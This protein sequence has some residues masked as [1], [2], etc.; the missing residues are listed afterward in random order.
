ML[1]LNDY[2]VYTNNLEQKLSKQDAI[3][4]AIT[5]S[6]KQLE[7]MLS[8]V[9]SEKR[10]LVETNEELMRKYHAQSTVVSKSV[11]RVLKRICTISVGM[12]MCIRKAIPKSFLKKTELDYSSKNLHWKC[13]GR[14]EGGSGNGIVVGSRE[15]VVP[16]D[17]S[18]L[19][20]FDTNKFSFVVHCTKIEELEKA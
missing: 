10:L 11:V 16:L 7:K 4:K 1:G 17:L 12:A 19:V 15:H 9:E 6:V 18:S 8:S 20:G 2:K 14:F 3:L 13:T 5:V